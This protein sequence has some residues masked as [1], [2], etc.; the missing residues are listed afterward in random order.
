MVAEGH[1]AIAG[2]VFAESPE[3]WAGVDRVVPVDVYVPG[4]PPRPGAILHGLLL[5]TGRVVQRLVGGVV[6]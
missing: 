3:V 1:E 4:D 6:R 5:L 2:G